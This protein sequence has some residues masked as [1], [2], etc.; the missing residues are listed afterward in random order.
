MS[1]R[2]D[3][4]LIE[5]EPTSVI[6]PLCG[7]IGASDGTAYADHTV[8]V[9]YHGALTTS[10]VL[11]GC[12]DTSP[13]FL[14]F[15]VGVRGRRA[16]I[17]RPIEWLRVDTSILIVEEIRKLVQDM[18]RRS[19]AMPVTWDRMELF[20]VVRRLSMGCA[21][22][23]KW[24]GIT[25][26]E[27]RGGGSANVAAVASSVDPV[28]ADNGAVF[29]SAK[30]VGHCR[31]NI[32]CALVNAV[33]G[34]GGT[35]FTDL[36]PVNQAGV[37]QIPNAQNAA[38]AQGCHEASRIIGALYRA[39]D[40]GA[41]YALAVAEGQHRISSVHG[42]T[43][44][45]AYVRDVMRATES[46]VPYGAIVTDMV[47]D[48]AIPSPKKSVAGFRAVYDAVAI[49]SAGAVALADPM[50]D[51]HGRNFPTVLVSDQGAIEDPGD[52]NAGDANDAV[53]LTT[54]WAENCGKWARNYARA[55]NLLFSTSGGIDEVEKLLVI[56]A[57]SLAGQDNR[58]LQVKLATAFF[59][60]EPTCSCPVGDSTFPAF[61]ACHGPLA[62]NTASRT[63]PALDGCA[64]LADKSDNMR[65]TIQV[66][67][68]FVRRH[69]LFVHLVQHAL[70]G[71]A[72]IRFESAVVNELLFVGGVG[73]VGPRIMAGNSLNSF[74]WGRGL[75]TIP[76][77]GELTSLSRS[78]VITIE[79]TQQIGY[80]LRNTH[81]PLGAEAVGGDVTYKASKLKGGAPGAPR[82]APPRRI[83]HARSQAALALS[84]AADA[85]RSEYVINA[86]MMRPTLVDFGELPVGARA[87]RDRDERAADP[88]DP[89]EADGLNP[90]LPDHQVDPRAAIIAGGALDNGHV[91]PVNITNG[92]NSDP[93]A[94]EV[95]PLGGAG[96][97]A[98][99]EEPSRGVGVVPPLGGGVGANPPTL[100]PPPAPGEQ[101]MPPP[102]STAPG[103]SKPPVGGVGR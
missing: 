88:P 99:G 76:A 72:N 86:Q 52:D 65:S 7:L 84:L 24:G 1:N 23:A 4:N 37:V 92:A 45:G 19:S 5:G 44:E 82:A 6:A 40:K 87:P 83:R 63:V 89:G 38:L 69:G 47:P 85:G 95:D 67:F 64:L 81:T 79:H 42:H 35:L 78:N 94:P 98:R 61:D 10:M 102:I 43:D 17:P 50:V 75:S 51:Y 34:E 55:L 25:P 30:L 57:N 62:I 32:M 93:R 66:D 80:S 26:S 59:W 97:A 48:N 58:H 74:L 101:R 91:A 2:P 14:T 70:N 100:P 21:H 16:N 71:T 28:A 77:G 73:D 27:L 20:G 60:L 90:V 41:F 39:C 12:T 22:Y 31:P 15:R 18:G 11:Q 68:R 103:G 53:D 9:D 13:K 56:Q 36:L 8:V 29:A 49:A 46:G 54:Q 33:S 96:M 3:L